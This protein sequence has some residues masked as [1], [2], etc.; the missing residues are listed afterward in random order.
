[1]SVYSTLIIAYGLKKNEYSGAFVKT[2]RHK[3]IEVEFMKMGWQKQTLKLS[4]WEAQICQNELAHL[5]GIII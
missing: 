3:N 1:M 5:Q 4:G 2:T